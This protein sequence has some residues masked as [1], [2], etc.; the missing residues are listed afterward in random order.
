MT[1]QDKTADGARR[2]RR[3]GPSGPTPGLP[4]SDRGPL[5]YFYDRRARTSA[6]KRAAFRTLVAARRPSC[7]ARMVPAFIIVGAQR[8]GTTSMSRALAEHPAV[9]GALLHQEVHYFDNAY[10]KGLGWYRCHFPLSAPARRS[11]RAAGLT[12][13]AFESSPYYLFHPLAAERIARDLPSVKLL[14]LLRDPVERAY[15]GH[16]HEMAH[17]FETEPF[18][19]ALELEPGRLE[20]E[21]QRIMADPAYVS[22]SHQHHSYRARGEYATQLERLERHFSRDRIHIVDSGADPEPAY[23]RVL[24]FL[25]LPNRGQPAF[26]HR[27]AQPRAP[28]PGSVRATLEEHY[29]PHDERLQAWLGHEPSWRRNGLGLRACRTD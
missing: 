5:S 16:A 8:C 21:E 12:P 19:R 18:E 27:N 25:G 11:A 23:D 26:P 6:G 1:P 4:S 2:G 14:V 17:G 20:G 22:F 10:G 28:M 29:R 7:Q 13:I 3:I 9:F 24:E 15:S